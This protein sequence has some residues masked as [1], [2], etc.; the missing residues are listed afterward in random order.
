[1]TLRAEQGKIAG[2]R[3]GKMAVSAVPG[4]GKTHTLA[5]LAVEL[6]AN[7]LIQNEGE[8]LVVTF[9][10]SAVET[11]RGR[12][13]RMLADRKLPDAGYRV[14]T[15]HS[16]A[17]S[18]IRER[19]DL[20][21]AASDYRIDDEIS[22]Q[23]TMP[24]AAR[25]F[26]QTYH[27]YWLSFLPEDMS[28]GQRFQVEDKWREATE[29][30][31]GE[32]TKL[33]KNLR[34]TPAA[35]RGL[36]EDELVGEAETEDQRFSVDR[37]ASA[38]PFLR[39]GTAIYERYDQ[40]MRAGGRLDFDDL[41]WGAIRALTNDAAF[42]KRLSAR[43]QF[44]LED[45]SQDSTP[46]QEVILSMLAEPHGNW[47]RVGDP[48]QAIMTT[49][50]ASNVRYFRDFMRRPD[51]N[52]L[53]LT[54]SGRSAQ[55]I[56][57]LAN[58][59]V[60]WAVNHHPEREVRR[61]A[62]TDETLIRPTEAGD[63]QQNPPAAESRIHLQGFSDEDTE[64]TKVAQNAVKFV[65]GQRDRTCAILVPTNYQGERVVSAL[66]RIQQE[67]VNPLYQD[68]LRNA[69]P[70]RD[71]ARVLGQAVRFCGLPTNMNALAD[72]RNTLV[73]MGLGV[74]GDPRNGRIK[75]LLRSARPERLLFPL[76]E[77]APAMPES[78]EIAEA[79]QREIA[80]LAT[81]TAKW[82]RASVLPVDQLILSVSQDLFTR[83]ADLAI[84]HS[85]AVS[86]RRFAQI[87]PQ[88]TLTDIA[89]ELEEIATNR[90]RYMSSSLI[91]AGF[92]PVEGQITV[93]TMHKAKGL[94]WDRV[95]LLSVDRIEFPHDADGEFRG[96]Q[97]F[98][99]GHDPATEARKALELLVDPAYEG[100]V[101]Q[102][103]LVREAHIEY[104]AER[105]RL[106]YVGITRARREL[107][108]SYAK[109][110][111]GQENAPALAVREV[112]REMA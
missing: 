97:W 1:M 84:A 106:L 92:E 91:E 62:L 82:V 12:I 38:S 107:V 79:D 42:R 111:F 45:E 50:T 76:D 48:N 104:I 108:I 13:R 102:V 25:W 95:Y 26:T 21:G 49:F 94:E 77:N 96:Q 32:V 73:E 27:D 44:I 100:L 23:N 56:I 16:L 110:R 30:L 19:P 28:S 78:I 39:I 68:Q 64:V 17:N 4:S 89:G 6:I 60:A 29:R 66:E 8:V 47:V 83:D 70:V 55:P 36:I 93:T 71:V 65:L 22:G 105:L 54:V 99:G 59:L 34:L 87:N 41:I 15:L 61:D 57:D 101:N 69:Q 24:E 31:G 75:T 46:L 103:D 11:V 74:Q 90:Q 51:V 63:A 37:P 40:I 67:H 9:T 3:G 80:Q 112:L 14:L 18:I 5:T 35:V 109:H 20:A 7:N 43:W 2:Y 72:L 58:E 81:L 33:A 88:A 98:L 53:P 85:L 52:V 10:N 86:L